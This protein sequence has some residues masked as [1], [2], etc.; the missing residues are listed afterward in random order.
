M[1]NKEYLF[2]LATIAV[3]LRVSADFQPRQTTNGNSKY[4]AQPNVTL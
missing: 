1:L 3:S 4:D 2:R